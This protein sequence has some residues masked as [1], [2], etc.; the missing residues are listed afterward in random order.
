VVVFRPD[1][2]SWID[3][4]RRLGLEGTELSR[5]QSGT[6]RLKLLKVGARVKVSVRRIVFHLSSAYPYQD[7][8]RQV[9]DR[10]QNVLPINFS[11]G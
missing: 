8:F 4:L 5:S 3:A 2:F 6:I 9:A 7:L 1:Q 10:L 11:F